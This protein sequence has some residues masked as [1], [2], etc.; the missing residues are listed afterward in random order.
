MLAQLLFCTGITLE[1]VRTLTAAASRCWDAIIA[2]DLQTFASA[3]I[4]S[5]NAQVSMFPGMMQ[6]G[7][8]EHID[9]W[10]DKAFAW[11][12]LGAEG[13]GH[14]AL[15]TDEI[16]KGSIRSKIRRKKYILT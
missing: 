12:M 8:Q 10:K 11:K 2:K 5:F 13:G 6:P 14:L 3:F 15:V 1:K 9:R 7:G 4:A 16:L